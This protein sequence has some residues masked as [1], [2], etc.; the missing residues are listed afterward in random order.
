MDFLVISSYFILRLFFSCLGD[1]VACSMPS[2]MSVLLEAYLDKKM[3][4][5][6]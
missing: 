1:L 6:V 5:A 4:K 3:C 2:S